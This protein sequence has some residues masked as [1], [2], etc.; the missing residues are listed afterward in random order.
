MSQ[1][2]ATPFYHSPAWLKNRKNYLNATLDTSGHVLT[3]HD[4]RWSYVEDGI[5]VTVPDACVVPPGM[6]ERCFSM[7]LL[8]PAKVV[9]HKEHL[10]PDNVG[11]PHVALS[12]DNFQRLCQD[13]HAQVHSGRR[14]SRVTFDEQGNVVALPHAELD[15]SCMEEPDRNIHR[16]ERRWGFDG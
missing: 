6:C 11:D 14:P 4:G 16:R 12:Y 8:E 3:Q 9:H 1:D 7:G 15:F 2:W 10:T 5:E 13:C